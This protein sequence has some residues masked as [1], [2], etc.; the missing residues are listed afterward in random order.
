M[1]VVDQN[2]IS[3]DDL[4]QAAYFNNIG[5]RYARG[6]FRF[7][8]LVEEE[9]CL[10]VS[11]DILFLRPDQHPLIKQGGDIDNRLKHLFDA[12]RVPDTT[13]GLGGAPALSEDPFFVFL[14]DDSLISEIRVSTGN[15]LMLP[16]TQKLD[17][18]E[19]FLVINVKL[20]PK[21]RTAFSVAFE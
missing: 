15:L 18:K 19:T 21:E 4:A 20:K 7:V 10:R 12:F 17:A 16:Q 5:N 14:H 8:P 3:S 9:T 11:I 13:D 6:K 1:P 2:G